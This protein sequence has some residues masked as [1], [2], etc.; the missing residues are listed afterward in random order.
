MSKTEQEHRHDVIEVGKLVFQ[1]GWVATTDGNITIRLEPNRILCTPT[2]VCKGMMKAEYLSV[3]DLDGRMIEG[4]RGRTSEI[5]MHL[6]IYRMRPDVMSV[7]H[8]HPPVATVCAVAGRPLN[9]ALLPEVIIGL[10]EVPLAEYGLPGTPALTAD[11]RQYIPRYDAIL[12]ANHGVVSYGVDVWKAFFNMETVEHFARITL[13]AEL[14]GGAR[15]LPREE[16]RKL[17]DA[18]DRYGVRSNTRMEPGSPV[19]AEEHA[20]ERRI[21]TSREEL[22]S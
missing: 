10:G 2:G 7:V 6:T 16:V 4:S 12:L 5:E 3:C 14:L 13:V 8:A 18:R 20:P 1:K 9:L 21:E 17:F 22:A 15:V 11:M 19:V